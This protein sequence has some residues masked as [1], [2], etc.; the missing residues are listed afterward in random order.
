M[1]KQE[2]DNEIFFNYPS[3]EET[4]AAQALCCG[5]GCTACETPAAYAWRKRA[6]DMS[7]LL[8]AAMENELTVTER[9]T[10][11]AFWFDSMSVGKIARLRGISSAAVSDTV[12]RA[13]EKL[14]KSLRYAVLYQHDTLSEE[15]VLPLAFARARA[16][17]AAR[18]AK[19]KSTGERI[20][21]LRMSR[22]LSSAALSRAC[23]IPQNRLK[24]IE[25][26]KAV[27]GDE[28]AALCAFFGTSADYLI[29][30]QSEKEEDTANAG[31][32]SL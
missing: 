22:G 31:K 6:V 29:G 24:A 23:A 8:E 9:E 3:E 32:K 19:P 13:Q 7:L 11:K 15:T 30:S 12:S 10:L 16:I 5:R 4:K 28:L 20:R 21:L 1:K 18:N 2:A 17:A 27:Y 25:E 26:G 14:K